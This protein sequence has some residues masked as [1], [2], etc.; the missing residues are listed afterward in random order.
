MDNQNPVIAQIMVQQFNLS[1]TLE[2]STIFNKEYP[3]KDFKRVDIFKLT[4]T[5]TK[6]VFRRYEG[7]HKQNFDARKPIIVSA[8]VGDKYVLQTS[9]TKQELRIN[10]S[11]HAKNPS[12]AKMDFQ[13]S[14]IQI[15]GINQLVLN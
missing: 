12:I 10:T 2:Q 5:I 1:D 13:E 3:I 14:L 7:E 6:A 8:K 4:Q 15:I 9:E 11:L